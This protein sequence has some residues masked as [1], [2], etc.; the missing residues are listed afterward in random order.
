MDITGTRPVSVSGFVFPYNRRDPMQTGS[1]RVSDAGGVLMCRM[2]SGAWVKIL[3]WNL[4]R[5]HGTRYRICG[6]KGSM[7][8]NQGDGRV[9][10]RHEPGEAPP[11]C[12]LHE[13]LEATRPPEWEEAARHGHGGGDW[14]TF[15]YF[16]KALETG[17]IEPRLGIHD[18]LAMTAIGIQGYRSA[19]AGGAP[20]K[21]PDFAD[22]AAR[23]RY[24]HDHWAHGPLAKGPERA[25]CT[26]GEPVAPPPEAYAFFEGERAGI[27]GP[28]NG[29]NRGGG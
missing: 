23:D 2:D 28:G 8:W 18:S 16:R 27:R 9:R 4:L 12:G 17:E 29:G 7:E 5:D 1:I 24:R 20:M 6:E 13:Y 3:P 14:F 22:S 26:V 25:P 11:G 21:V 19:L 10:V 15:H